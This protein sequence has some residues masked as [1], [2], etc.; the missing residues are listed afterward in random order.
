MEKIILASSS[1]RRRDLLQKYNL[2]V[3]IIESHIEERYHSRDFPECAA[4][5][6]AFEKAMDVS[7]RLDSNEVVI[8]ADTIVYKNKI[9]GKPK[10]EKEALETLIYLNGDEHYVITGVAIVKVNSNL[11]IID[12]EKTSV[13]FR[14]LDRDKIYSYIKTNEYKDKAGSYGIQGLGELLV[15]RIEGSYSNVVGLPIGKLDF[16]LSKYF[17]ISLLQNIV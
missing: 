1:P 11:K 14:K 17:G 15:E 2:N 16:L 5:S 4:M 7:N 3:E 8:A 10:D 13:K 6:L 12:Y 9:L